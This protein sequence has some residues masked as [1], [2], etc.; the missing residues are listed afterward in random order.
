MRTPRLPDNDRFWL[1]AGLG[2]KVTEKLTVDAAY[3]HLFV[4]STSVN[5]G[6]GT[7]NPSSSA[8]VYSGSI[9]AHVDIVSLGVKY[10]WD[11]PVAVTKQRYVK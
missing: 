5:L 7:G 11:E 4:R 9:D 3:S 8:V 1:S 6:P 2:Y 10:R